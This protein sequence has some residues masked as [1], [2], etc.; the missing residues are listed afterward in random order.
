MIDGTNPQKLTMTF[1]K[2]DAYYC[3]L[4]GLEILNE[5]PNGSKIDFLFFGYACEGLNIT[6]LKCRSEVLAFFRE[7]FTY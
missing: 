7:I 5:K 1:I 6:P 2:Y 3:I 4:Y